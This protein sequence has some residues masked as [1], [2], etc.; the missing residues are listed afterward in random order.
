MRGPLSLHDALPIL[1]SEGQE[2]R[3]KTCKDGT[4]IQNYGK[5][6]LIGLC[7]ALSMLNL[8]GPGAGAVTA[9][10]PP[11]LERVRFCDETADSEGWRSAFRT[12]VDH[13]SEV[14]PISV[15]K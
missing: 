7:H 3:A 9:R 2:S 12:D 15:P 14:M 8:F 1:N 6:G 13:D 4:D 5:K 10:T 11:C